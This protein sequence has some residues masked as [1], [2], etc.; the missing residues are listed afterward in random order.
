MDE[1]IDF[2]ALANINLDDELT[3]LA[4]ASSL[5]LSTE[6]ASR[7]EGLSPAGQHLST[8]FGHDETLAGTSSRAGTSARRRKGNS[9]PSDAKS[10]SI[11]GMNFMKP[12]RATLHT[13]NWKLTD[14]QTASRRRDEDRNRTANP[15]KPEDK[16]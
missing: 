5:E 4:L 12:F 14:E 15:R 9:P 10:P 6:E 1:E 11:M 2:A 8:A 13:G 7:P 3:P 16:N